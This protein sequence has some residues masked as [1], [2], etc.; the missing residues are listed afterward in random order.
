MVLQKA[1]LTS[2]R[3]A[4]WA[5]LRPIS[6]DMHEDYIRPAGKSIALWVQISHCEQ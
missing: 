1:T 3:L 6:G 5:D 4:I 2:V